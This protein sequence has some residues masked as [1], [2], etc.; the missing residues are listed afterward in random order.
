MARIA[1][2]QQSATGPVG[3]VY[4]LERARGSRHSAIM[5]YNLQRT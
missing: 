2:E 1:S 4:A 5:R 3:E